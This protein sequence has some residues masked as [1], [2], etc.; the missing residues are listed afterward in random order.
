MQLKNRKFYKSTIKKY[1]FFSNYD[2]YQTIKIELPL[3]DLEKILEKV[4]YYFLSP[5]TSVNFEHHD[6][7]SK[8]IQEER[9]LPITIRESSVKYQVIIIITIFDMDLFLVFTVSIFFT[10]F[11]LIFFTNVFH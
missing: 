8:Q 9:K 4:S 6:E 10:I 7:L 11:L 1:S 3:E 2:S 5:I